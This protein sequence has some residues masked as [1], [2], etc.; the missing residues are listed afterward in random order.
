M[1]SVARSMHATH[2]SVA[3]IIREVAKMGAF[4][5]ARCPNRAS[6]SGSRFLIPKWEVVGQ[7]R[8]VVCEVPITAPVLQ[9]LKIIFF[10]A[11]IQR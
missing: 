10:T 2:C 3:N 8:E 11:I 7:K 9:S 4:D 5:S 6:E 1:S